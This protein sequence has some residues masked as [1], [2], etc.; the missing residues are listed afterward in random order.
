[1][2]TKD[3]LLLFNFEIS[4]TF[5]IW[6]VKFSLYKYPIGEKFSGNQK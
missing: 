3:N 5:D 1:M 6:H 4:L 2:I